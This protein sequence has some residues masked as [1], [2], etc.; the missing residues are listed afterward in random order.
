MMVLL[1][2]LM[3]L[4]LVAIVTLIA[5]VAIGAHREADDEQMRI[6]REA[7]HA[8]F[9]LHNMASDAFTSMMDVAR[10]HGFRSDE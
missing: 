8:A 7:R 4:L 5:M 3:S 10:E 2:I 9:H 1:A 6:E